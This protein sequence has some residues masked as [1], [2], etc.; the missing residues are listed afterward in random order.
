M[1][2][3]LRE[4]YLYKHNPQSTFTYADYIC[5]HSYPKLKVYCT[6]HHKQNERLERSVA[7]SETTPQGPITNYD[8]KI[9]LHNLPA[10]V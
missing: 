4:R 10:Y 9:G 8:N 7:L 2:S 3:A 6:S 1:D 5:L